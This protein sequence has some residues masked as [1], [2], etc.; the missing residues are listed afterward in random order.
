MSQ[1]LT[2]PPPD[3]EG[4]LKEKESMMVSSSSSSICILGAGAMGAY[5]ASRFYDMDPK[6]IRL[7]AGDDRYERL[8]KEGLIINGKH[9]NIP[10]VTPE[11]TGPSDLV[12]VAVKHHQLPGA[13]A[14]MRNAVGE[15]TCILSVMN[16]IQSEEQIG[17]AYGMPKVLYA[18]AVGIDAVRNGN[19]VTCTSQGKLLFGEA[20]NPDLSERVKALKALFT[21]AG[22]I[23]E[24]PVDMIRTLW[25]KFMVN[26]GVNQVSA[27]LD[28]PYGV[29][30]R[31][32]AARDLTEDAMDEVIAIAQVKGTRLSKKDVEDFLPFLQKMSPVGKTSMVQDV[33]AGRKTEVEMF[34]GRVVE[35]GRELNI[36]TPVNR[37]LLKLIQ[38]IEERARETRG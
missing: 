38:V 11:K 4:L 33:E 18:V 13:I 24:T 29:F 12:L 37:T 9:Y 36:P 22:I 30:Q 19:V 8:R 5:Y 2:G 23:N 14:D 27:I 3:S 7:I 20:E 6:C 10:V 35:M 16:G 28:A 34:A 31:S 26:V 17:E 21:R 32:Q 15:K 1:D 25:W